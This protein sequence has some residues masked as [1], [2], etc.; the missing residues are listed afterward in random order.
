MK[1]DEFVAQVQRRA[2]LQT[3]DEAVQA[4]RA[5]LETLG[6]RLAGGEA[7]DLAAQLPAEIAIYLQQPLAG[8]GEPF[9]LDD[10]FMRIAER[11]GLEV[12][13]AA[14]NARVV[15]GLLTE[16][17]TM[18]EI[19]NIRAQLPA[20]L[21]QLFEVENEGELPGQGVIDVPEL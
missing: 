4:I 7:K 5:T 11:E 17:V 13:E 15:L 2:D 8:S 18:G 9:T 12:A 16:V 1:Y 14:F 10:F 3:K 21:R 20:E 6:E 19:E